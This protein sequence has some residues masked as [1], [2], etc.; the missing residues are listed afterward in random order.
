MLFKLLVAEKLSKMFVVEATAQLPA[1][2][3]FAAQLR[4]SAAL[5]DVRNRPAAN[6]A[7]GLPSAPATLQA[8]PAR[9]SAAAAPA[10][11]H[12]LTHVTNL[13][14]KP[15]LARLPTYQ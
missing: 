2:R 10:P 3:A 4:A 7:A 15:S 9:A 1:L 13:S 6:T 8:S 14:R 11:T 5:G 12:W